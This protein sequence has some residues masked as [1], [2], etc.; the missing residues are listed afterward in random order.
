MKGMLLCNKRKPK[1][2]NSESYKKRE[3]E[4]NTVRE[5][6]KLVI[7]MYIKIIPLG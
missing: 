2:S 3:N 1:L 4:N 7:Y 6:E 5:V